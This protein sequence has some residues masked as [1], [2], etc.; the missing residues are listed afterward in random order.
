M[1]EPTQHPEIHHCVTCGEIATY[2][3]GA[4]GSGPVQP[5]ETWYCGQHRHD[6]ERR[7]AAR[8]GRPAQQE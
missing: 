8:Y 4:P 6:G 5:A 2:G 7:W 1:D 3:F